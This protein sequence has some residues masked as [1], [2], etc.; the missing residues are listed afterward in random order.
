MRKLLYLVLFPLLLLGCKEKKHVDTDYVSPAPSF[1]EDSA[2][3]YVAE[4]CAFG[5]R[6]MNSAAHDSCGN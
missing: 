3:Q 1:N 6:V 4:Q 5:P 2:F